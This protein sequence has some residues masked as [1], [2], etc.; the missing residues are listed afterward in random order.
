MK[1]KINNNIKKL[2]DKLVATHLIRGVQP[3]EIADAVFEQN[4]NSVELSKKKDGTIQ[5]LVAFIDEGVINKM[6]YTYSQDK[7]LMRIEQKVGKGL[8]KEQWDRENMVNE[9]LDELTHQLSGLNSTQV[10]D[11]FI[12]KL[13]DELRPTLRA[14]LSLV[15]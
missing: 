7:Y 10:V 11:N 5:M 13:P 1:I 14:K 9:M 15:A 3:S 12:S 6:R 8:F 2:I 4:Y